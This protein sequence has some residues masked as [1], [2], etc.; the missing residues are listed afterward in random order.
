MFHLH[1]LQGNEWSQWGITTIY[2]GQAKKS[3]V[4]AEP[5]SVRPPGDD[6][7]HLLVGHDAP[8]AGDHPGQDSAPEVG[9]QVDLRQ[10][11]QCLGVVSQDPGGVGQPGGVLVQLRPAEMT[12]IT[13]RQNTLGVDIF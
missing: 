6:L 11:P 13:S 10:A 8:V 9:H 4:E 3:L 5:D 1:F 12:E 7:L 2:F